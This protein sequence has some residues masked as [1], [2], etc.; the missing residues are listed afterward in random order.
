MLAYPLNE[1]ELVV[2]RHLANDLSYKQI[3]AEMLLS[4]RT[5]EAIAWRAKVKLN[6]HTIG[7]AIATAFREK[8]I[9]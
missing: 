9:N 8:L 4:N 1:K 7:G 5:V 6:A 3:G 2:I